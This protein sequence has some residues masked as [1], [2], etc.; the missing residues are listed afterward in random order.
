[1]TFKNITEYKK[2]M[3]KKGIGFFAG[4]RISIKGISFYFAPRL[5][6]VTC[7]DNQQQLYTWDNKEQVYIWIQKQIKLLR[8]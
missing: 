5:A 7:S 8:R 2:F 6:L 4:T 1:M 3:R